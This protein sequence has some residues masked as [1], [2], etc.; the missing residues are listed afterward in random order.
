MLTFA[1]VCGTA[2]SAAAQPVNVRGNVNVKGTVSIVP[3]VAPNDRGKTGKVG[4]SNAVVWLKRVGSLPDSPNANH[5]SA[6]PRFEIRQSHKRFDPAILAVPAGSVV[7]FPNLDPFFHNVFSMYDG[8]RFDLGLYE[9]GASH[10][11]TFDRPGICF[12]FCNIHPEMSA[13]VVVVEGPYYAVSNTAGQVFIPNVPPGRYR[14]YAWHE[15]ATSA[16]PQAPPPEIDISTDNP[17]LPTIS[18]V[19]SFDL[20]APHKNKYG[21]DYTTPAPGVLYK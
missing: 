12:I 11:V 3:K 6:R 17:I 20:I 13:V 4:Q 1:L 7:W 15:R 14:V 18:L 5:S 19:E 16:T 8:N 10:S 2:G 21:R 9:A